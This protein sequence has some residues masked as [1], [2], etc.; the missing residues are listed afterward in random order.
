M[1][2][3]AEFS[4]GAMASEFDSHISKSIRGYDN[5]RAD[6]V[7]LSQ[8]FIQRNS[9][10]LDL[11]CSSGEFLRSV[12]DYNQNRHASTEYLGLDIEDNFQEQWMQRKENNIS[13]RKADVREYAGY[14]NLSVVFS[15]F[16]LQFLSERDRLPLVRKIFEGL[17]E[18][19]ALILSEKVHAKNAKI[20]EML[21]FLH[22]DFK[23]SSFSSDEILNKEKSIRDQMHLWSEYKIFEMLRAAGFASNNLQLFW[24]NHSFIGILAWKQ[25]RYR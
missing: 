11:G 22:Y 9:K 13:F 20:Q 21:T 16:T 8:Y 3:G 12:R 15:L 10:V 24:R 14:E 23:R 17:N 25:A 6:C 1:T 7:G 19:G 5:L 2:D 18:G 4:F